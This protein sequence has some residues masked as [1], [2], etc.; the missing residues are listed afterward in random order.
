MSPQE[1]SRQ[2]APAA[3]LSGAVL[4]VEDDADVRNAVCDLLGSE[5]LTVVAARDGR[6]ALDL[7]LA[8]LRPSVI[9]LDLTMPRMDGWD[10]RQAQMG[11]RDLRDIPV[12]V[13]TAAGFSAETIRTQFGDV[14]FLR[15]PLDPVTFLE[16]VASCCQPYRRSRA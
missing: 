9:V 14:Q 10:F 13:A 3:A 12:I 2:V 1:S 11:D 6:E 7:L 8:G 16:V 15:K 4:L 5:G